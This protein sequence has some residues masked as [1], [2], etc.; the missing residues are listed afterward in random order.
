MIEFKT[1]INVILKDKIVIV[2]FVLLG[3]C[4]GWINYAS[5]KPSAYAVVSLVH[6]ETNQENIEPT[7]QYDGYYLIETTR[8]FGER[9][10]QILRNPVLNNDSENIFNASFGIKRVERLTLGDYKITAKGEIATLNEYSQI[11]EEKISD[12]LTLLAQETGEYAN[13]T[14]KVSDFNLIGQIPLVNQVISG[15]LL[16]FLASIMFILFRY[17]FKGEKL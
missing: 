10:G 13:F 5:N 1:L 6:N 4:L 14:A 12:D 8:F 7:Y 3:L 11:L 9:L 2:F 15:A 16:G 17:Y